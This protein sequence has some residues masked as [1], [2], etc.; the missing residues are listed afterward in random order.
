V[1]SASTPQDPG[2][3]GFFQGLFDTR[4][5]TLVTPKLIRVLY[6]IIIVLLSLGMLVWVIVAFANDPGAGVAALIFA[7]IG[8]LLYLILARVYLEIVIVLFKIRASVENIEA[9]K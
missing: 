6:I 8:F 1:E 7:P 5:E 9:R 2:D 3:R 4:F